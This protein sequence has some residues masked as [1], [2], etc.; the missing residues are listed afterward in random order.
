MK[1]SY[2]VFLLVFSFLSASTSAQL[3]ELKSTDVNLINTVIASELTFYPSR[4]APAKVIPLNHSVIPSEISAL[5]TNIHV[6]VG[7][8]VKKG[9]LLTSLDCRNNQLIKK[10]ENAKVSSLKNQLA[11]DDREAKRGKKL[12]LNKNIGDA[13]LDRRETQ[14]L[15]TQA[16]LITQKAAFALA[17]LNVKR[18]EIKAPFNGVIT[19]RIASVGNMI[20]IG[21]PVIKMLEVENSQVS[22]LIA[23]ADMASFQQA[24]KYSFISND[25]IYPLSFSALVPL[26]NDNARSQEARFTLLNNL[27]IAGSNGRLIWQSPY[28]F[29]PAHLLLLRNKV[30]GF[31]IIE[32]NTAKFISVENAE[33]GRPIPLN[34][35][36]D[37]LIIVEGRHGLSD[38]DS[39]RVIS[40]KNNASKISSKSLSELN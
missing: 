28:P 9:Q 20:D 15:N 11:F 27:A 24:Q 18:C 4:S 7:Q 21:K 35:A 23:N 38:G 13:E 5:I 39:V 12:A 14:L 2:L 17:K 29:L 10:S 19:Q 3:T 8:K 25:I 1:R 33:E 6:D 37:S 34:I 30:Y 31:F 32:N 26:I 40:A 16:Q 22:A 36:E